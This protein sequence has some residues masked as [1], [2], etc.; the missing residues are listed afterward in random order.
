MVDGGKATPA[1]PLGPSL[2]PTGVNVGQVINAINEKTKA[3]AGMQ[4]PIKVI[5][6]KEKKTFEIEVGTPPTSALIKGELGIK[7]NVKEE[8]GSKG[9]KTIGN[10]TVEQMKKIAAMKE[11]T[12]LSKTEDAKLNEIAGTCLSMGVTIEGKSP[13]DWIKEHGTSKPKTKK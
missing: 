5:I 1:P 3:F 4:V 11:N 7:E 12:S 9:K 2:A 6:E 13:K 10:I 8:A